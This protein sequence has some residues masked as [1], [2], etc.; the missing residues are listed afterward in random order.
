M[1]ARKRN[2]GAKRC[3]CH[4]CGKL[5]HCLGIARHRSAHR[6][7]GENCK[8]EYSSGEIKKYNYANQ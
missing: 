4:T 8:I 3:Y 5:Y 1:N 6:R 2:S 7:K